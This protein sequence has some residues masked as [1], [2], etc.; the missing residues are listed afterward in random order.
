MCDSMSLTRQM[1][2]E[3]SQ[4]LLMPGQPIGPHWASLGMF[5]QAVLR[6]PWS[7]VCLA[8]AADLYRM[9]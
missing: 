9:A 4:F 1:G 6:N 2:G 5:M 7:I 3:G 8:K